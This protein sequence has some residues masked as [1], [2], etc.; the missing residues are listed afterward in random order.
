MNESDERE[1]K[2]IRRRVYDSIN[3]LIA[4]GKIKK[5]HK[6]LYVE[7]IDRKMGQEIIDIKR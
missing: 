4:L 5:D 7:S 3:V 6:L 1:R 2:T